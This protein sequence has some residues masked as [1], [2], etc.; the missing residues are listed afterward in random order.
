MKYTQNDWNYYDEWYDNKKY[1]W[2]DIYANGKNPF[3]NENLTKEG[4]ELVD[5][6]CNIEDLINETEDWLE[7]ALEKEEQKASS[8]YIKILKEDL[9]LLYKKADDIIEQLDIRQKEA[10]KKKAN[11][12]EAKKKKAIKKKDRLKAEMEKRKKK[13]DKMW[14]SIPEEAKIDIDD[15]FI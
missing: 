5:E 14:A 3:T 10:I 11:K 6:L 7:K 8:S 13:F 4:A 2:V 9:R 15:I 1:S 12:K